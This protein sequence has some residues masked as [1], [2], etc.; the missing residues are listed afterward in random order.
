MNHQAQNSTS[1]NKIVLSGGSS[2]I[3]KAIVQHFSKKACQIAFADMQEP[4]SLEENTHFTKADIS[5]SGGM[6][7]F[8]R[9]ASDKLGIPDLLVCN[10]GVGIHEKL[11]EGDP[12]KWEKNINNNL[13]AALRMIRAFTPSMQE[14]GSGDVVI[15]TSVAAANT[16]EYGGVYAATKAALE[17]VTETLRLEVQPHLRVASI[18]PGVVN[19]QFFERMNGGQSVD[20]IGWGALEP[21]EIAEA[22]EYLV[23]RPRDAMVNHISLRPAKQ[24]L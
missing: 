6:D 19:T 24:T 7:Q 5:T 9:N 18:A 8:Y 4:N 21:L 22:I 23:N 15:I 10:A 13:M 12:A 3:G 2:G 20:S 1:V 17:V 14:R 16:Y 11:T